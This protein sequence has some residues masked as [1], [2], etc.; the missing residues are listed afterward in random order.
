LSRK[1]QDDTDDTGGGQQ[2]EPNL[3]HLF[4]R[5]QDEG[6]TEKDNENLQDTLDDAQL[7]VDAPSQ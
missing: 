3:A 2:T 6:H 5:E 1:S 4:K 7:C